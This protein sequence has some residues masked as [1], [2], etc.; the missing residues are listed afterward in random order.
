M[1][2]CRVLFNPV[3]REA[4]RTRCRYRILYGGAGSGKSYNVAQ[5]F[6]LKLSDE[7]FRGANLL[8]IRRAEQSNRFSTYAEL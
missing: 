1:D 3:F 5:D 4:N 8:V 6:I 7:R 2:E